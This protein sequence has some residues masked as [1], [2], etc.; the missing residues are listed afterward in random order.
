MERRKNHIGMWKDSWIDRYFDLPLWSRAVLVGTLAALLGIA[1]DEAAHVFGFSWQ[2]EQLSENA[3]QGLVIGMI[4][5]WLSLLREQRMN[6]RMKEI[7]FLNHHIRNAMQTI[8]FALSEV[9][10]AKERVEII[11]ASVRRV[12]ETLSRISR[13]SDDLTTESEH[14]ATVS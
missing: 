6:R 7:G 10:D 4:V 12:A 8:E 2:A 9:Q 1:L 5:F 14:T 11:N 3:L 13:Q